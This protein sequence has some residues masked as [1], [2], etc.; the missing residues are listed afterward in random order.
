M[1]A[2]DVGIIFQNACFRVIG[3]VFEVDIDRLES[4]AKMFDLFSKL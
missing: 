2:Y 3:I 1:L 4:N